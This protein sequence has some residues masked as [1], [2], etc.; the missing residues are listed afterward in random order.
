[1]RLISVSTLKEFWARPGCSDAEQPLRT[2]VKVVKSA[3]WSNPVEIKQV[4]R[5]ADILP[6]GRVVFDIGGNKYRLVAAIHYRG[7]RVYVRF[8]GTHKEY[9]KIDAT[10]V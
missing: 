6:N 8:I 10:T 2:W 5:S 9:D 7:R 4:F 1:M 3:Q